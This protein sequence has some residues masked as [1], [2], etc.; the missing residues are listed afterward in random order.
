MCEQTRRRQPGSWRVLA[1]LASFGLALGLGVLPARAAGA[2]QTASSLPAEGRI[3]RFL[4]EPKL[5]LQQVFQGDRFPNVV[6][7]TDGSVLA[8][9]NGVK[10]RRSEDG[11]KTWGAEILVGKG[12]MGGGATVDEKSGEVLAFVETKHQPGASLT[13]YR[14]TDHGKTWRPQETVIRPNKDGN[15]PTMHMNEHGITLRHGKHKGRLLRPTRWYAGSND[16]SFYPKHY[17]DAIYSDDGGK[18]WKT[19]DPFPA[20]GTGEAAVVE[21]ADGRIYYNS[22]RHWDPKG[23]LRCRWIAWSDDGGASWKDCASCRILPDG[24]QCSDYGLMG[25]LVRL[26]VEGRD[27]LIFS[28]IESP[29]GRR[30]GTVWASFDGGKTWPIKRLV[31][32]GPFAYSSLDAGR[33][34]TVSEGWIYLLFE[35]GPKGG[36]TVARFNLGWLLGGEKT[37]NGELPEWAVA[38]PAAVPAS[39]PGN[40]NIILCMTDDQ[41]WGDTSYNGHPELKTPELDKMAAAGIRFDRFFTAHPMCSPT[42]A[43][44][45]TGRSPTRYV[46]MSWGHDLPLQEVTIAEAVKTAGYATGHFG[47]WHLGGIEHAAGGTGRGLPESFDPRPRHPGNQGFD[48]WW[49]AGN[50][51]DIGYEYIYHHGEQVP[52]RP[53]DTSDVLMGVALDWIGKQAAAKQPFLAVIWFPSPH[54]P[55]IATPE[56]AKPYEEYGKNKAQYYGELAGVDH[57]MGTL[58]RTLRELKIADNTML[59][60][61]SDNGGAFPLATGGLPGSKKWLTEGGTRVPGILEWPARIKQPFATTVPACTMD[62]YPT[63]L[64]VLGI[65]TASE[66]GP[67]DGIS[68]LPLIDGKMKTR[69]TPIPLVDGGKTRIVDNEYRF[70]NGRLFHFDESQKKDVDVTEE[71]PDV[72]NRLAEVNKQFLESVKKDQAAYSNARRNRL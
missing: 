26:P 37:G 15:V 2:C 6:V 33:P 35:G 10:V 16:R 24:D 14:S 70:Q 32:E 20:M 27:I 54:G 25:G 23:D 59:W 49:S 21:L 53:G 51:Y 22:R 57:A 63:T 46:C 19:S 55:H 50:N 52:P 47:K 5:E 3:E 34:G 17:T 43:S 56:Y 38:A 9:W 4:G 7:A 66:A 8:F 42:R 65:K 62:F 36:G 48:E 72:F 45:M 12:F 40:P 41:G 71:K 18:T 58:R 68:L 31:D 13:V 67:V 11:G 30:H 1:A 64:D 28:N 60:F 39:A 69:P 44:C 29:S 61:C